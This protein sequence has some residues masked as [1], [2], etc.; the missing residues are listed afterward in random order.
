MKG[1]TSR[2]SSSTT[3]RTRSSTSSSAASAPARADRARSRCSTCRTRRS[4]SS[5]SRRAWASTRSGPR[6]PRSSPTRSSARCAEPGPH[7]IDVRSSPGVFGATASRAAR[8]SRHDG[9]R[10]LARMAKRFNHMELTFPR[11]ALD[12]DDPRRH[13]R[14]LR[15]DVRLARR[16]RRAVRPEELPARR[17]TT[18]RSHFILLAEADKPMQAPGYDHLGILCDTREEVDELLE[19]AKKWRDKDDRVRILEFQKDL[20]TGP[21]TVHAFY[22]RY[23][24]PIQFDVQCIEYAEGCRARASAGCTPERRRAPNV[25]VVL[26]DSLN[27]HFLDCYLDE[28][29]QRAR[30]QRD[31]RRRRGPTSSRSRHRT[32]IGSR[33]GRCASTGTGRARCRACRLATTCS[34]A[35]STSCGG[36]GGR[37]RCGRTRSPTTCGARASRRC[38]SPTIRTCSR[39]AARTTTPTSPR[40]TTCAATRAIRGARDPTRR[41]PG[42]PALPAEPG[43]VHHAVRRLAHVVPRGGRLP[44]AAHDAGGRAV[45]AHERAPSRPLPAVRRRVRSARAVRHARAV[46][47][48]VRRRRGTARG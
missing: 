41:G 5:R 2:R 37:S 30:R 16:R 33:R 39:S 36:R 24:L 15:R 20:V 6:P 14:L 7:L 46:G 34:S 4:T 12:D 28:A 23:L 26:L 40:G 21:V 1:S 35:R 47:D 10:T 17:A 22:V 27:R 3:G 25:V 38:S 32:S 19:L 11:G 18:A 8:G 42:T 45:A 13:R 31:R 48:A 29:E 9:D 43:F 44:R